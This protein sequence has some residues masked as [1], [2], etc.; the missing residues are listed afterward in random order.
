V[1][2]REE[3]PAGLW[4]TNLREGDNVKDPGMDGRIVVKWIF[5]KRD[6]CMD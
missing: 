1:W 2:W 5:E 3:V 4:W 6:G